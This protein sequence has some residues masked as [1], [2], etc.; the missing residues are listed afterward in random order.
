MGACAALSRRGRGWDI[1]GQLICSAWSQHTV[2]TSG[3]SGLLLHTAVQRGYT[4]AV[5]I[6]NLWIAFKN[7]KTRVVGSS[8]GS[9]RRAR[10]KSRRHNQLDVSYGLNKSSGRRGT[11][12]GGT[13]VRRIHIHSLLF[14]AVYRR[15]N[16]AIVAPA[17]KSKD[18]VRRNSRSQGGV[19]GGLNSRRS[20]ARVMPE[21]L[22]TL[23]R[24]ME[25]RRNA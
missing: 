10:G 2:A 14:L 6:I 7:K 11:S 1:S 19:T 5:Y 20:P 16:R 23:W 3:E 17:E 4:T 8:G 21:M 24:R 13:R 22:T 25:I 9:C 15:E 12:N 18:D